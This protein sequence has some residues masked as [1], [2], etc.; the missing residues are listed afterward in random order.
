MKG[1]DVAQVLLH[2][3]R[4]YSTKCFIQYLGYCNVCLFAVFVMVYSYMLCGTRDLQIIEFYLL[5]DVR[6]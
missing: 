5:E 6:I 3:Y 1:Q 2:L 4:Q